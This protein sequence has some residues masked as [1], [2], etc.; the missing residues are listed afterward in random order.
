[1]ICFVRK[2][3]IGKIK[4]VVA[5]AGIGK[6]ISSALMEGADLQQSIGGV[7]TLFK[8]SADTVKKYASEAY[9][10]AGMSANAIFATSAAAAV[11]PPSPC[12]KDAEKP[13]TVCIYSFA[14]IPAVL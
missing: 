2:S 5:A 9:K 3:M 7:E 13:V 1:M 6:A 14:D 10:T 12:S 4:T 8:D 11:S